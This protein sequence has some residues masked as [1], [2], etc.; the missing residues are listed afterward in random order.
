MSGLRERKKQATREALMTAALRLALER[1]L[2][3]VRVEDIAAAAGVSARTYNN[4]FAS[5]YEAITA[6]HTDRVLGAVTALRARPPG[7]P[8]WEA[9]TEAMVLPWEQHAGT[10]DAAP[11]AELLASIRMLSDEPALRAE[12]LRVAFAADGE[13]AA[14][15]A[16]RSGTNPARDLYPHLVAAAVTAAVQAAVGHWLR[17]DP[18][19]PLVPLLRDSL[20]ALAAGLPAPSGPPSQQGETSWTS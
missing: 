13:L 20:R 7:E 5:K 8:F 4:Y 15:V 10:A 6:R 16:E 18:P 11:P 17:A 2:E 12:S 9:V 1:G 14:A 19:V 3:N